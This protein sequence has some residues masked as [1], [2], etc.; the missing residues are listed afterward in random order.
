[1]HGAAQEA[2]LKVNIEKE[3]GKYLLEMKGH[4]GYDIEG[5]DI[6][7]AAASILCVTLCSLLEDKQGM[8]EESPRII[9]ENGLSEIAFIPKERYADELAAVFETVE[10][11]LRLL[12][13]NY[14]DYVSIAENRAAALPVR[15]GS[16][17]VR[18]GKEKLQKTVAVHSVAR[19]L[20]PCV[21][22]S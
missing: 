11:G 14:P 21:H 10:K 22:G 18:T 12:A 20:T 7:C 3:N 5:R 1:M 6:V 19:G 9:V 8:L 17:P 4:C 15:T 2:M 13:D 16:D